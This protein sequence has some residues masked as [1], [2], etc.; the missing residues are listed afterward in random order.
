MYVLRWKR[1]F[2]GPVRTGSKQLNEMTLITSFLTLE[3]HRFYDVLLDVGE[4]AAAEVGLVRLG[5]VPVVEEAALLAEQAARGEVAAG[6][7]AVGQLLVHHGHGHAGG[8]AADGEAEEGDLHRGDEELKEQEGD[9]APHPEEALDEEGRQPVPLD[10]GAAT[11][12]LLGLRA[13]ADRRPVAERQ[14]N[15]ILLVQ[16]LA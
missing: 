3:I 15:R 4:I 16:K 9:V 12:A 7:G 14:F 8:A 11:P 2:N 1:D 6:G 5:V 13:H 10:E